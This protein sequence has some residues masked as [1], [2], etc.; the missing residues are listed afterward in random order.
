[1]Q[2]KSWIKYFIFSVSGILFFI[3]LVNYTV[4]PY[5]IFYHSHLGHYTY[6]K[7]H[8]LSDR[9]SKFYEAKHLNPSTLMMGSS[10]IGFFKYTYLEPYAPRPVYNFAMA[11]GSIYEQTRYLEYM[12]K[13]KNV[14][15]I[16]WA[17]DFFPFNPDKENESTFKDERLEQPVYVND[18]VTALLNYRT[19]EKSIQTVKTNLKHDYT[20]ELNRP[21][22]EEAQYLPMQGQ[23]YSPDEIKKQVC[24]TLNEYKNRTTF[25]KSPRFTNPHSID[26]GLARLNYI[27]K[28]CKEKN[29]KCILYTSPVYAAHIDLIYAMGLGDTF[30]YWKK[31]LADI[32]PYYDFCTYN[33]VTNNLLNFRDS[34]HIVSDNGKIIF[35][36]IFNDH[37]RPIPKDF[38]TYINLDNV[39][40]H[41]LLQKEQ[42]HPLP[43]CVEK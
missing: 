24:N 2:N 1:M 43:S 18:Y 3:T 35:A 6:F 15:T 8:A 34:A 38:G 4:N 16:V 20:K 41:L 30:E 42:I 10:R 7:P 39:D 26:P 31:S 19:F 25:L 12:I 23:P 14:K 27:I 32:Q 21:F 29:I 11:G 40:N 13:H 5:N 36:K 22:F 33:S 17:I 37:T 28:L 9:M